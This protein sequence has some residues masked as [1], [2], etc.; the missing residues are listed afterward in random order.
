MDIIKNPIVIGLVVGGLTY[1][2]L[3]TQA[4]K[5]NEKHKKNPKYVKKEVNLIIPAVMTVLAWFLAYTLLVEN[6]NKSEMTNLLNTLNA[7]KSTS[8]PLPLQ[9]PASQTGYKFTK[10]IT[11]SDHRSDSSG[12][13]ALTL[14]TGGVSIPSK[15]TS[16]PD[17]MLDLI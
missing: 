4:D 3:K 14:L 9:I 10:D 7:N 11:M 5:E 13:R 17:M 15:P 6:D 2:Y 1:W 12:E 16:L 8:V